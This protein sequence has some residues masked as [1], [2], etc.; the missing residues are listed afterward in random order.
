MREKKI[1]R[2]LVGGEENNLK[3]AVPLE[4]AA[5]NRM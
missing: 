2:W 1:L 5:L 4:T 3:G